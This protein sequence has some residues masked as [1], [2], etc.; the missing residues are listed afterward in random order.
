[1]PGI[2]DV[3]HEDVEPVRRGLAVLRG[4]ARHV[5]DVGDAHA[6]VRPAPRALDACLL[7]RERA[8][9]RRA[10][11][12][13]F[14]GAQ[15]LGD[16]AAHDGLGPL[17]E[18]EA[19]G[20]VREAVDEVPVDEG[21]EDR[22]GVGDEP[23][24]GLARPQGRLDAAALGDVVEQDGDAVQR[25]V[26]HPVG[27]DV[28]PAARRARRALEADRF[29]RAGDAAV[30]V[31]PALLVLRSEFAHPAPGGVRE[32]GLDDE[33]AV[34]FEESEIEGAAIRVEAHLDQAEA[35]VD[36]LEERAIVLLA[37]PEGGGAAPGLQ[38]RHHGA[39]ERL[40]DEELRLRERARLAV[41]DAERADGVALRR[42]QRDAGVEAQVRLAEDQG[43]GRPVRLRR[44]VFENENVVLAQR[45]RAEA[46][47]QR[48]CAR[49][50]SDGGL[51]PLP[52]GIDEVDVRHRRVAGLR[53][54]LRDVVEGRLGR[55]VEDRVGVKG[56]QTT[57]ITR[58]EG[59]RAGAGSQGTVRHR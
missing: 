1:M 20:R 57:G 2:G 13:E 56:R 55:R 23:Q 40:Q 26:V 3:V 35:R 17:P 5:A 12:L 50:V 48:H 7:A 11:R 18:P 41:E 14:R 9:E 33:G 30:D 43:V 8:L 27:V 29:A 53:R 42:R 15:H 6:P 4:A 52:I 44:E 10:A 46:E 34:E 38:L 31:E 32:P 49:R 47:M 59:R 19:V 25:R 37:A 51:D 21:D 16:G 54:H 58:I 28:V 45:L 24:L 39:G 22:H 36:R